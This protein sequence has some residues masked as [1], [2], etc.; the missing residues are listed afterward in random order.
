[1]VA[2]NFV[3][4][5]IFDSNFN[6]KPLNLPRDFRIVIIGSGINGIL[7]GCKLSMHGF[8]NFTIME[9]SS[10]FGGTWESNVYPGV[11]CDIPT[12]IYSFSFA[13]YP[14]WKKV[15]PS[16][17]EIRKYLESVAT[18]FRLHEKTKFN[19]AVTKIEWNDVN[20]TWAVRD[21]KGDVEVANVVVSASGALH[22]PHIP[23]YANMDKFTKTLFH[24]A[25]WDPT[26]DLKDKKVA[27]IGTG[28]TAIQ[29]VPA[30][31]KVASCVTVFQ[32]SAA[33]VPRK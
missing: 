21:D 25:K 14:W 7:M 3:H 24:A 8:R 5:L 16:G 33:W 13:L 10:R 2:I 28:A 26:V 30:S 32:R 11:A 31:A 17:E 15:Y 9:K 4:Y 1:M 27:V 20:K 22:V 29:L 23:P 6:L 18:K 19:T 12:Q